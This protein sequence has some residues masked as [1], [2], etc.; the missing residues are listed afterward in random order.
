MGIDGSEI[1]RIKENKK[2]NPQS[3]L[4]KNLKYILSISL[5][6]ITCTIILAVLTFLSNPEDSYGINSIIMADITL[7]DFDEATTIVEV[8]YKQKQNRKELYDFWKS[9][10]STCKGGSCEKVYILPKFK[11]DSEY[12]AYEVAK[13]ITNG[14]LKSPATAGYEEKNH[15]SKDKKI[16]S[17]FHFSFYVDSGNPFKAVLR[18]KIEIT[19]RNVGEYSW[20]VVNLSYK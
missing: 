3:Y 17:F 19:L 20:Y 6:I 10:I 11:G 13:E 16:G 18:T 4:R 5:S 1:K 9:Y 14:L 12:A 8:E 2:I 15:L 7:E